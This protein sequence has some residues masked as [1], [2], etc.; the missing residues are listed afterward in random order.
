[1]KGVAGRQL[2][3]GNPGV[4]APTVLLAAET[5]QVSCDH[6]M[7]ATPSM[8]AH[9]SHCLLHGPYQAPRLQRGDRAFCHYRDCDVLVTSFSDAPISWPL[10]FRLGGRAKPGPMVDEEFLR[11]VRIES[12]LAIQHHWGVSQCQVW[13]WRR[14]FGAERFTE[15]S[16]RLQMLNGAKRA[17]ALRGKPMSEGQV[18]DPSQRA[19]ALN[20]TRN[21]QPCPK[22][23]GSHPWS[24]EE[25]A[26]IGM[27]PDE[28]VA[29][30]IGRTSTAVRVKRSK[31][32]SPK[33][34]RLLTK[35]GR[36]QVFGCS[37]LFA[38]CLPYD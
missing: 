37:R 6:T 10:C 26:L 13:R 21:L 28:Q 38:A 36:L 32:G 1:V 11:A 8:S 19:I 35:Y 29:A 30:R 31:L 3:R 18:R 20:L 15:G 9:P 27:M 14:A 17:D 2:V 33:V 7:A 24:S 23:G 34:T 16:R 4:S 5:D 12:S 25:L 22:P